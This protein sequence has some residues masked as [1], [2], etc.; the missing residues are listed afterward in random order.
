MLFV[1]IPAVCLVVSIVLYV[2]NEE[3]WYNDS[4]EF[5]M[6]FTSVMSG[7]IL[8]IAGGVLFT[9][10]LTA[11]ADVAKNQIAH[12]TI[13]YQIE[14]EVF[15]NDND[16]GKTE[17]IEKVVTWNS[18]VEQNRVYND[19][20]WFNWFIPDKFLQFDTIDYSSIT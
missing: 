5:S 19:S 11:D 2:L 4:L 20:I 17:L 8:L 18:W 1:I 12:D 14:N 16:I 3:Y 7:L 9:V 13:V 10:H 15:N 6:L